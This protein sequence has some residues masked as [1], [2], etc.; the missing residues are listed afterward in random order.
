[1]SKIDL[2]LANDSELSL[3]TDVNEGPEFQR[4]YQLN[5]AIALVQT[6]GRQEFADVLQAN[7]GSFVVEDILELRASRERCRELMQNLFLAL[8]NGESLD[9]VVA[10][11]MNVQ[12]EE[13]LVDQ[14]TIPVVAD[15][16]SVTPAKPVDK[17]AIFQ[18]L[19]QQKDGKYDLK[20]FGDYRKRYKVDKKLVDDFKERILKKIQNWPMV[21]DLLD[22]DLPELVRRNVNLEEVQNRVIASLGG[23][24][25]LVGEYGT[26]LARYVAGQEGHDFSEEKWTPSTIANELI[27]SD[28][29]FI[30][31][32]NDVLDSIDFKLWVKNILSGITVELRDALQRFSDNAQAL[33]LEIR[34]RL[35]VLTQDIQD[36]NKLLRNPDYSADLT[37]QDSMRQEVTNLLG[38]VR[39]LESTLEH[40][41]AEGELLEKKS[42]RLSSFFEILKAK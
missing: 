19:D 11:L 18:G 12:V 16:V 8:G 32:A 1:M 29:L 25:N 27:E 40:L 41:G 5:L 23:E 21:E 9:Q 39:E 30:D 20:G 2:K 28:E 31:F 13:V 36:L 22:I 37:T 24:I 6:E 14:P 33:A 26:L 35:T 17:E 15:K 4:Q 7:V 3:S 42:L 38:E 10:A 34:L